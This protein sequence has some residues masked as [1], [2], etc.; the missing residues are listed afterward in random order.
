MAQLHTRAGLDKANVR[1]VRYCHFLRL[2]PLP[3]D[4]F[5]AEVKRLWFSVGQ[6]LKGVTSRSRLWIPGTVSV[7]GDSVRISTSEGVNEFRV[8]RLI[9]NGPKSFLITGTDAGSKFKR[10]HLRLPSHDEALKAA[11]ML[12]ERLLVE[13]QPA[14]HVEEVRVEARFLISS[15][16]LFFQLYGFF[17][18]IVISGFVVAI[19]SV[20]GTFGLLFGLGVV[21]TYF[22]MRVWAAYERTRRRV[23]AWLRFEERSLTVTTSTNF[24]SLV[25]KVIE[26]K[27]PETFLLKGPGSKIELTLPT[28]QEAGQVASKI[29]TNFS[30]VREI[31]L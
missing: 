21:L 4:S 20:L 27:G 19:F 17:I 25:P 29:K 3:M 9:W 14:F 5:D 30:K 18:R 31:F 13:E 6:S 10:A 22:G 12:E 1:L 11:S 28:R 24:T 26:W 8:R 2:R 23:E 16:E 15:G 7:V